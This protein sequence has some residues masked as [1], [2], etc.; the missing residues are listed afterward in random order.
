MSEE[1]GTDLSLDTSDVG[2][3]V[4]SA[5]STGPDFSSFVPEDYKE[6]GYVKEL[7]KTENPNVELFK[8]FDSL[9]K[10][11]GERPKGIPG[12]D[13]PQEE[14][15][16]FYASLRPES[17][18][19]YTM[20]EVNLGEGKEKIS[21]LVKSNRNDGFINAMRDVAQK[22]ALTPKQWE[23]LAQAYETQSGS[24]YEQQ[25]ANQEALEADF[26]EQARKMFG[27]D[28]QNVLDAGKEALN[29]FF[30][31]RQRDFYKDASNETLLAMA[32]MAAAVK[33][34]YEK[35]DAAKLT[36]ATPSAMT[37][38]E[39]N[40]EQR[41]LMATPEYKNPGV[42]GHEDAVRKVRELTDKLVAAR[43]QSK[44]A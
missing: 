32:A 10:K 35:E 36:A 4:D 21:E 23:A 8:Q 27:S 39:L 11:L 14:W 19:V 1:A 31:E 9:Q 43:Q 37:E 18:D 42:R 40:A 33:N 34:K 28:M 30:T 5:P 3:E 16:E 12:K 44:K 6:K 20:P 38:A 7:L 26:T 29:S 17:T 25:L 41:R 22:A 2:G 13:A 24:A 15:D